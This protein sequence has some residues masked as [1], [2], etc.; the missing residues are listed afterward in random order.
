MWQKKQHFSLSTTFYAVRNITC[1]FAYDRENLQIVALAW[2][3]LNNVFMCVPSPISIHSAYFWYILQYECL[4]GLLIT[5]ACYE[6]R[7]ACAG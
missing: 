2:N 7:K 1:A 6:T 4:L 5:S 3:T